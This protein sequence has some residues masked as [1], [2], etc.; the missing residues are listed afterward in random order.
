MNKKEK[1]CLNTQI[2]AAQSADSDAVLLLENVKLQNF[3]NGEKSIGFDSDEAMATLKVIL[4]IFIHH[5]NKNLKKNLLKIGIGQVSC[6]MHCNKT[7]AT[8]NIQ[9]KN[10]SVFAAV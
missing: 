5:L 1:Y 3:N 10:I 2:S 6:I 8:R 9:Y 4:C 7:N